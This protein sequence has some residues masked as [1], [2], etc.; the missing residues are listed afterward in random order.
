EVSSST[1]PSQAE[2]S[3]SSRNIG[4]SCKLLRTCPLNCA[5]LCASFTCRARVLRLA[6][7]DEQEKRAR[8]SAPRSGGTKVR[9]NKDQEEQGSETTGGAGRTQFRPQPQRPKPVC[10]IAFREMSAVD[11]I[12]C[13]RSLNSSAFDALSSAVS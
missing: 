3:T 11:A 10:C 4:A 2:T 6:G 7:T 13:I 1:I 5:N 8:R 9:R 12:P